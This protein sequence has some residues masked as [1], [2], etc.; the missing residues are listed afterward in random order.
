MAD[1]FSTAA[2]CGG[3]WW[4]PTRNMFGS[5]LCSASMNDIGSFVAWPPSHHDGEVTAEVNG[6]PPSTD[7]SPTATAAATDD[8]NQVLMQDN[9]RGDRSYGSML[10]EDLNYGVQETLT[11][12]PSSSQELSTSF[13]ITSYNNYPPNLLKSMFDA[14]PHQPHQQ[15]LISSQP[16]I[17]YAPATTAA[18]TNY[19][20][21]LSDFSPSPPKFSSL[22]SPTN[23][24]LQFPSSIS[25]WDSSLTSC[26][27]PSPTFTDKKPAI[28]AK[29]NGSNNKELRDSSC[30]ANKT[31]PDFKRPR[32]ETPSPLPTFKVRKEKLGDRI[33]ALQQLVSPFGKTDTASVLHEAIEYIKFLHDQV[34]VLITPY[35]KN[36]SPSDQHS[37]QNTEEVLDEEGLS[38]QDLRSQGLCL[39]P[40]SSTFPVA[41]ETTTDFWTPTFGANFR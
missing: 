3:G 33:T 23:H 8:W 11:V 17:S 12:I 9:E 28:T 21:N 10:Q 16:V 18:M 31:K 37:Q 34:N 15:C 13:P 40:M 26:S 2:V 32:I 19:G 38:K 5:Y 39:V 30:V 22:L 14:D 6:R 36:G 25:L 7:H 1:E 24:H 29:L 4:N 35:M 27:F 20:P 41:A